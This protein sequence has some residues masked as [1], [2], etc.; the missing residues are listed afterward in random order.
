MHL[1]KDQT[2]HVTEP[3]SQLTLA[4]FLRAR[5]EELSWSDA[6]SLVERRRVSLNGNL[7]VD[8]ARRLTPGEVVKVT[9]QAATKPAEH[10]QV[11]VRLLDAQVIVVEKPANVTTVRHPEEKDWPARRKQMQPTLDEM[12]PRVI[13]REEKLQGKSGLVQRKGALPAVR[14][15]HRLDRETSG[16]MV[17]A[18]TVEAERHLGRQFKVHSVHR[19]YQAIIH[20]EL[21]EEKTFQS[22][23]VRDRGDGRRGSSDATDAGKEAITHVK[24]I[25]VIKGFTLLQCQLETGRTHQIRIHLS[26]AGFPLC[27]EKVYN[28]EK[29]SEP[30]IDNTGAPRIALHAA[31]LGFTHPLRNQPVKFT[32]PMPSDM[33]ELWKRLKERKG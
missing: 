7:C 20:G 5:W 12:L 17:F 28:R 19:L 26:E 10:F 25:E 18:R 8:S 31:E 27:G 15:V 16:L 22:T 3:E 33:V 2:F 9:V 30:F 11:K 29:F 14:A 23:L 1:D 21:K 6:K 24:P 32:M 4:A 13:L